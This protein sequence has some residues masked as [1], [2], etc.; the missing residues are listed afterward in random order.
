[1]PCHVDVEENQYFFLILIFLF[2]VQN[3]LLAVYIHVKKHVIQNV[4][5]VRKRANRNAYVAIKRRNVIAVIWCGHAKR[6]AINFMN[7]EGIDVKPNAIVTIVV[8]VLPVYC[9][10]ARAV[11]R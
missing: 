4:H 8:H 1:M 11:K 10:H 3:C 7:V 9:D 2:S 5:R 6:Y